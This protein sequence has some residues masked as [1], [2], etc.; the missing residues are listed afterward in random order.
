MSQTLQ[1]NHRQ[2]LN[3]ILAIS[4]EWLKVLLFIP[5]FLLKHCSALWFSHGFMEPL[6]RKPSIDVPHKKCYTMNPGLVDF[7]LHKQKVTSC[8]TQF[9][10]KN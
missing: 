9:S 7:Y 5:N 10:H 2:V 4:C 8:I 1:L 6:N 3:S